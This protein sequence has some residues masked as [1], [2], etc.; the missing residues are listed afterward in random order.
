MIL[1]RLIDVV[2]FLGKQKYTFRGHEES[3]DFA[4]KEMYIELLEILATCDPTIA[5]HFKTAMVFRGTSPVIQND[6]IDAVAG[7][8]TDKIKSEI[9]DA[10]F[11]AILLNETTDVT[12]KSQLSTVMRFVDNEGNCQENFCTSVM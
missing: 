8:I 10:T 7:V 6:L 11:V 12:N 2:T 3:E 4:N 5:H 9:S 1:R